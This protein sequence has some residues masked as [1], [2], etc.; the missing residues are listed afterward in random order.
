M[1]TNRRDKMNNE[2]E[3]LQQAKMFIEYLANGVDPIDNMDIDEDTF[4]NE[5]I[6]D[7]LK[8]ISDV[9]ENVIQRKKRGRKAVYITDKQRSQLQIHDK[10]KVSEIA[11]EINRVIA[12]ND[13]RKF[14]A[15]WINDWLEENGY[16]CRNAEGNRI[17]TEMGEQLGIISKFIVPDGDNGR[18]YYINYYSSEVQSYIFEHLDEILDLRYSGKTPISV[19]FHN[20]DFPPGLSINEFIKLN[21]DKCFILSIGNYD[22]LLNNGSYYAA[23]IYKGR[24]KLLSKNN[25]SANSSNECILQGI[26]EAAFAIKNPTDIIILTAISLGFNSPKN[27]HYQLCSD[28]MSTLDEKG[29]DISVSVCSGKGEELISLCK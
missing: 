8:Y 5:Q 28:I 23:L 3:K 16:L 19:N 9:L 13:T 10:C 4:H 2:M 17:S 14:Q 15:S 11:N 7:C 18:S 29:C 21:P 26:M 12:E 6:T 20:I 1:N 22:P 24:K 25:I 27:K